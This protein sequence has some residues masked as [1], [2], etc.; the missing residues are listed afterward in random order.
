MVPF[1]IVDKYISILMMSQLFDLSK[2][3]FFC[4]IWTVLLLMQ[5]IRNFDNKFA[6]VGKVISRFLN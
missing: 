5:I 4:K 1:I 2:N 3:E 6:G